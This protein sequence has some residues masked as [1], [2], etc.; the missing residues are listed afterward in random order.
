MANGNTYAWSFPSL[1]TYNN[2]GGQA[3]VVFVV[4]W[5]LTATDPTQAYSTRR[6]GAQQIAPYVSGS[7]FIPFQDLTPTIVEGWMVDALTSSTYNALTASLD[8]ALDDLINPPTR[9][10]PPPWS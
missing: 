4:N 6:C 3:N 7:Q 8:A 9:V 10:L 1:E 5:C 2:E